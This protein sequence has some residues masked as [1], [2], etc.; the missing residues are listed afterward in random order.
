MAKT[1]NFLYTNHLERIFTF[2]MYIQDKKNKTIF[3]I[4]NL[5]TE[6]EDFTPFMEK[7]KR[8]NLLLISILL[9][10]ALDLFFYFTQLKPF[11]YFYI[12]IAFVVIVLLVFYNNRT[13]LVIMIGEKDLTFHNQVKSYTK[14]IDFEDIKKIEEEK[15]EKDITICLKNNHEISFHTS[16]YEEIYKKIKK[17]VKI[18]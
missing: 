15:N 11:V 13:N 18:S 2:Q 8:E 10:S 16:E 5:N 9:L 1:N 12:P 14:V 7:D 17:G 3:P 4:S 6:L